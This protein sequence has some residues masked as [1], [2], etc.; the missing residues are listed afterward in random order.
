M[1]GGHGAIEL[2]PR[3]TVD[4]QAKMTP[5]G[6]AVFRPERA[7]PPKPTDLSKVL[8]RHFKKHPAAWQN[9]QSFRP[10]YRRLTTGWVANE[11]I[12]FM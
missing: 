4:L 8:E 1:S 10:G 6:L 3:G 2:P 7:A 9:F 11:K 5:A 12:A